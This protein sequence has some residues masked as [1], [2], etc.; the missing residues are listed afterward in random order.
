MDGNNGN[1]GN[2]GQ[3]YQNGGQPWQNVPQ[4]QY[5]NG[6]WNNN[7]WNG[8]NGGMMPQQ[9]LPVKDI[10]CNFLLVIFVLQVVVAGVMINEMFS[11]M[12]HAGEK[13]S[14]Y[15]PLIYSEAYQVCSIIS[16]LLSIAMIVFLVLDI[17]GI[18]KAGYKITGLVL[19]AIFLH[20]GYYLWRAYILG[21]KKAVPIIYTVAYS[22]CLVVYMIYFIVKMVQMIAVM[23]GM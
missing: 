10:F 4:Q 11:A 23:A 13:A 9:K 19:F 5:N 2:Y 17:V 16:L 7:N 15:M 21:R 20:P 3:P 22:V 1:Y 18:N 14:G 8:Y 12:G 6:G